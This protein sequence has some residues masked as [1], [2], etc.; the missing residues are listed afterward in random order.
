M[1]PQELLDLWASSGSDDGSDRHQILN[2]EDYFDGWEVADDDDWTQD[3]KYQH[4]AKV[5]KH[6]ESGRCFCVNASRSGSY[7]TDWYYSYD[8]LTEV[9][10]VE[11]V[12]KVTKWVTV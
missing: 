5:I 4:I 1:S 3:H 2:A 9:K 12:I 11:E 8:D 10:A 7:H 6:T